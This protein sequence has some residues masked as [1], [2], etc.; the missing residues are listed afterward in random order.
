MYDFRNFDHAG[1]SQKAG[2]TLLRKIHVF[3]TKHL[4]IIISYVRFKYKNVILGDF[5]FIS[6]TATTC[7]WWPFCFYSVLLGV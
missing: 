3:L 4:R 1:T 2:R 5:L 6:K 7:S